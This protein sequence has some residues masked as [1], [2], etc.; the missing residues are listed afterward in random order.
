MRQRSNLIILFGVAFLLVG[1]ALVFLVLND[2]DSPGSSSASGGSATQ[3]SVLVA[4]GDIAP[5]TLGSDVIAEGLLTTKQMAAGTQPVGALTSP[6]GL[7]NQIFAVAVEEGA[8][9]TSAQLATR[10]LSNVQVPEGFEAVAVTIDYTNGGAGYVAPGDRVNVYGVFGYPDEKDDAGIVVEAQQ[11]APRSELV[12]TNVLVLDVSAQ[13]GTSVQSTD[14]NQNQTIG[15]QT[16]TT[17]LTYLLALKATDV[18][19]VVQLT[20]FADL[21]LSLT[22]DDAAP[23]PD[24]PGVSGQNVGGAASS[25]SAA[26]QS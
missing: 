10:S 16:L 20:T 23:T 1:G 6:A 19:R 17:P 26:P 14:P 13:Q 11:I 12:L 9:I 25:D 3:V 7:E 2:D 22:A 18:E 21:Y 8:V 5:N 4:N 15:R 24:T